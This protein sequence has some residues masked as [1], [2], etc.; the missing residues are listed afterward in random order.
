MLASTITKPL[1]NDNDNKLRTLTLTLTLT[2]IEFK[3][4]KW[5]KEFKSLMKRLHVAKL[6]NNWEPQKYFSKNVCNIGFAEITFTR[7]KK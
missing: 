1:F 4:F 7:I 2:T 5:F 6:Q 3:W